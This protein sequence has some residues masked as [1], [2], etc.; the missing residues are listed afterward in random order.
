MYRP[1]STL[2][3][4]FVLTIGGSS[5]L[6]AQFARVLQEYG[7]GQYSAEP[8]RPSVPNETGPDS[9]NDQEHG[10]ARISVAQGD[11]NVRRGDT[12][13]LVAATTNAP[14]VTQDRLQTAEGS[15]AE[16]ELDS[17]NLIRLAPD[18]DIGVANLE[19]RHFQVQ[20]GVGAIIYR[21]LRSPESQGEVDT[22][23]IALRA[24]G[25]GVFRIAVLSDGTTQIDVRAGSAEI[26]GP[27]GSQRIDAGHSVAVRGDPGDPEF[28]EIAP[29]MRDQFDD[30]S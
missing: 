11:V 4:A 8:D 12:S 5:F 9:T 22:P 1:L 13:E 6:H 7:A 25:E 10:V 24:L 30:W 27:R 18:T 23:S 16:I 29:S 19:Y 15:R 21:V 17:A 20:L 14:L 3:L 28:L 26:V 2:G